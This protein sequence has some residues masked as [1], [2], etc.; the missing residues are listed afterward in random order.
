MADGMTSLAIDT[1]ITPG[2]FIAI[3]GKSGAGKTTLLRIISGLMQPE[4]GI[5]EV[6]G[7]VWLNT[8]RK[9]NLPVQKRKIGFVFQDFALFPNMS[10]RRNI[11]YAL[12]G[13]KDKGFTNRLLEMVEMTALADRKPGTLSGGQQQRVAMIRALATKPGL[14]LLDEPLSALDME[15]R[16][17]LRD[18][19]QALHKEFNLTTL[20]VTHDITDI[21]RLADHVISIDKGKIARSGKPDDLFSE[22]YM[23]SKLRLQGEVLQIRKSGVVFIV[24]ILSGN[25][26]IKVIAGKEEV[27]HLR[28]GSQVMVFSKAFNPVIRA[29]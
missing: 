28:T 5:I 19:L 10:V 17:H 3:F 1:E 24:E 4:K 14:L 23:S 20:L 25:A 21:Y 6:N 7:E 11:R 18:E 8:E 13:N 26:I 9:I 27:A 15:M 12:K 16:S 22:A 2:E 29:M